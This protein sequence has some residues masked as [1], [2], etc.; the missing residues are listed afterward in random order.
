MEKFP[1]IPQW[2]RDDIM[3]SYAPKG[4]SVGNI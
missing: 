3:V 2:R 1:F 4:G